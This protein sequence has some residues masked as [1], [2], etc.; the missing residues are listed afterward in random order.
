MKRL[1]VCLLVVGSVA[2]LITLNGC[3]LLIPVVA[4]G[5]VAYKT[6]Q[7]TTKGATRFTFEKPGIED[8]NALAAIQSLAIWPARQTAGL[9]SLSSLAEGLSGVHGLRIVTPMN[10]TETLESN[11]LP[12][13]TEE[14]T[15]EERTRMFRIVA[16]KTDADAVF[17]V[18]PGVTATDL[19]LLKVSRAST[20]ESLA[21]LIYSRQKNDVIWQDTMNVKMEGSQ[22]VQSECTAEL[23]KRILEIT[24]RNVGGGTNAP[25]LSNTNSTH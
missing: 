23:T 17:F 22:N 14:M 19:A 24:G 2:L 6:G 16:D 21:L 15:D 10:V 18:S 5:L 1:K 20:T 8:T 7:N 12:Q 13:A 25:S 11:S 4:G 9:V 3:L